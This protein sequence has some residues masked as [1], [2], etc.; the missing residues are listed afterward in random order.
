MKLEIQIGQPYQ[1]GGDS[2]T[3]PH[4]ACYGCL[5]LTAPGRSSVSIGLDIHGGDTPEEARA[6]ATA[7]AQATLRELCAA[8]AEVTG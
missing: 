5:V 2:Y 3:R 4:W 7:A 6:K 8:V 1:A